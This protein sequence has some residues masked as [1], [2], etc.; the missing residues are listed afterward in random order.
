MILTSPR[1]SIH[2]VVRRL[3]ARSRETSKPQDSGL[4]FSN[5]SEIWQAPQQQCCW[6]ACQ[7]SV[8]YRRYDQYNIQSW[9]SRFHKKKF[10]ILIKIYQKFDPK[11]PIDNNPALI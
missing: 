4:D 7:I 5:R 9:A 11:G 10:C 2:Y 3:T 6:D 1:A 8:R